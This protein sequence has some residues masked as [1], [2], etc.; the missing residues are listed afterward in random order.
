MNLPFRRL[1][2]VAG[3]VAGLSRPVFPQQAG[4]EAASPRIEVCS[5]VSK[6]EVKKH[7]P[8]PDFADGLPV[9]EE[10]IGATGSSC[11]YPS[12]HVQVLPYSKS[13]VEAVRKGPSPLLAVAGIGDEAHFRNLRDEYAE[14]YVKVGSRLLTLQA[15]AEGRVES[16]KPHVVD[17]AELYVAKLR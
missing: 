10:P 9:D 11:N 5:L 12:V 15:D 4:P 16:V 3:I 17:L 13:F 2:V 14:L 1:A 8:W 6:E 7:L